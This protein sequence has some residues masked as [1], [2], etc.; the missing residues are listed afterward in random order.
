M[1]VVGG[2]LGIVSGVSNT[3][4]GKPPERPEL[5]L[6]SPA[7]ALAALESAIEAS[8]KVLMPLLFLVLVFLAVKGLMMPGGEKGLAFVFKPNWSEVTP[9][10]ILLA[11]GQAFFSLSLGQGTMVTYGSYLGKKENVPGTC[12]PITLF[13]VFISVLAGIAISGS[14]GFPVVDSE[15][16]KMGYHTARHVRLILH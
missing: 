12:V 1:E 8:N 5:A 15:A 7:D 3:M 14:Q 6:A 2:E 11:L 9:G 10:A 16:A 4:L 13:G